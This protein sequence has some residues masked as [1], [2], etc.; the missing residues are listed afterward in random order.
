MFSVFTTLRKM[1]RGTVLAVTA[2]ALSA[3]DGFDIGMALDPNRPVAVALLVPG[4]SDQPG[5]AVLARS[6]ENA[7]R[8][9]IAD[10]EGVNFDLR[11]YKTGTTADTAAAAGL[12]AANDGAKIIL[13][14]V[15]ADQA[16]AVG[17]AVAGRG[18]N[19]LSFSNNTEI[20]GGNL[21]VLGNSFQN[22]ADRVIGYAAARGK[23]R[24][25]VVYD[26]TPAGDIG[27]R[28]AEAA[29]QKAGVTLAGTVS[30]SFSMQGAV[31]AVPEIKRGVET[32]G[33]DALFFTSDSAGALPLFGQLLPET[34]VTPDKVQYLG[35]TRWDIPPN[36]LSLP[37]LQ[38]GWFALSDPGL[39]L[40]FQNRYA[41]AYGGSE[42][43]PIAGLAY[44][45]IAAIGA[46][47]KSGRADA[48]STA[49][50]TQPSGFVGVGG[51]F[52]LREDG[53]CERGLAIAEIQNN[54]VTIVDP[55]PR[56]FPGAGS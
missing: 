17:K 16:N 44:D 8:L 4:D 7:A 54:Q 9:A 24:F 26:P 37:G 52:R 51:I 33:A 30:Y 15:Y 28:A 20:A 13:G 55:A 3:C 50:L 43:H 14:P 1:A 6:L 49:A 23:E 25:Y 38:G 29:V 12:Q 45:G 48:L 21:F 2:L 19:V 47:I 31:A 46:L 5:D 39:Q 11:V 56:S 36:T 35:L 32:T 10:L 34:G 40:Q 42:P 53:T 41:S 27:R 18:I 22:T